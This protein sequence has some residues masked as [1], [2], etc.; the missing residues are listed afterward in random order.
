[1]GAGIF[2]LGYLLFEVPSNIILHRVGAKIWIPRILLVW[3]LIS[4]GMAWVDSAALFYVLRF[5][6]GAGEAGFFPCIILYLAYWFP[7][8][9]RAKTTASFMTAI[10][11][12]GVVGGPESG[13]IMAGLDGWLR[14]R[15]WQWLFL[16][17]CVPAVLLGLA[18]YHFLDN[19]PTQAAWLNPAEKRIVLRRLAENQDGRACGGGYESLRQAF[20]SMRVWRLV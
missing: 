11:I 9:C 5:L 1:M 15:G 18:T 13:W 14:L 20:F 3:G 12:A 6:L 2:F 8:R 16:L 17:E 4:M 19:G 7:A 10:A